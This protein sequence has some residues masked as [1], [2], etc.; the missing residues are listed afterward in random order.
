MVPE[1]QG[2]C[3]GWSRTRCETELLAKRHDVE[4]HSR[5]CGSRN[6]IAQ[7]GNDSSA[8]HRPTRQ[9]AIERPRYTLH[10]IRRE[11][12]G[13]VVDCGVI[14]HV[15]VGADYPSQPLTCRLAS[16]RLAIR[17]GAGVIACGKVA[18]PEMNIT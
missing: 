14:Q 15:S 11:S 1:K 3:S 16:W 17:W 2:D 18:K 10:L 8:D 7:A 4:S 6:E 9:N 12:A 5:C 13:Y